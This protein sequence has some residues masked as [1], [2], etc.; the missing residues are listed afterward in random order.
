LAMMSVFSAVYLFVKSNVFLTSFLAG[1]VAEEVVLFLA[2]LAGKGSIPIMLVF[3]G[4]VL[5]SIVIDQIYYFL[6]R[7]RAVV[8]LEKR[9]S[10]SK[11]AGFLPSFVKKFGERNLALEIFLTKF[12]YGIR[13]AAIIFL[14]AKKVPYRTFFISNVLAILGWA[15]IMIP[16][17]YLS[18]RGIVLFLKVAKG[19]EKFF[20][21]GLL[22]IVVYF[23]LVKVLLVPYLEKLSEKVR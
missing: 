18:G 10:I 4:G 17:A 16:A 13:S 8:W 6:G 20:L 22:L 11:K 1:L 12:I 21:I 14:G 2:I 9:H 23:L 5:G 15:F 3:L 7:S 19:L